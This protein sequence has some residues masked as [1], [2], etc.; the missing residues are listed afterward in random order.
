MHFMAALM[1]ATVTTLALRSRNI[2]RPAALL[3]LGLFFVL[4]IFSASGTLHQSLHNDA[5][6]PGHHCVLTLFAQGHFSA[7]NVGSGLVA[8]FAAFLFSLPLLRAAVVASSDYK[9]SPS[10]A[11]PRF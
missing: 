1:K 7:P 5:A 3:C 11:P 6:A 10:R 2:R 8:V 9:L 4:Q